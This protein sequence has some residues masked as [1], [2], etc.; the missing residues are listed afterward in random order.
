MIGACA[1]YNLDGSAT[2]STRAL[3]Q[4]L[5]LVLPFEKLQKEHNNIVFKIN[6]NNA[7]DLPFS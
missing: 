4:R 5:L 6:E 1:P 2:A 3:L 7:F